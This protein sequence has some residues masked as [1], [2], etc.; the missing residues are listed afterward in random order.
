MPYIDDVFMEPD[1]YDRAQ[2][3]LIALDAFANETHHD[4]REKSVDPS[5]TDFLQEIAS[6]LICDLMHLLKQSDLDPEEIIASARYNFEFE[7]DEE[8]EDGEEADES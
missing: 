6:D 5:D 4:P 8:E 3:A 7:V 1:N 2:W